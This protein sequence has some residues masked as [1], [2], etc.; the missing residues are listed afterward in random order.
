VDHWLTFLHGLGTHRWVV[1]IFSIATV[2]DGFLSLQNTFLPFEILSLDT[3]STI[4]RLTVQ[5]IH[6]HTSAGCSKIVAIISWGI[7]ST[8]I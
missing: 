1:Q 2:P 7:A 3:I 4:K 8:V 5:V 6:R